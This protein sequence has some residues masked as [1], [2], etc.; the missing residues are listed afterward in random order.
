MNAGDVYARP[1]NNWGFYIVKI[2]NNGDDDDFMAVAIT[3]GSGQGIRY[4]GVNDTRNAAEI[5]D[6]LGLVK[7]KGDKTLTFANDDPANFDLNLF[8]P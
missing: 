6:L 7:V 8:R 3:N 1:S 5:I 4:G 2:A